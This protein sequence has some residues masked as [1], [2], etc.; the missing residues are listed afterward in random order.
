[1][2]KTIAAHDQE[3][4]GALFHQDN[5]SLISGCSDDLIKLWDSAGGECLAVI[6]GRGDGICSLARGP[7]PHTFIAGRKD[8]AVVLWLVINQLDFEPAIRA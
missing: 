8:G 6:D 1:L 7:M 3:M 2:T 5:L 4:C